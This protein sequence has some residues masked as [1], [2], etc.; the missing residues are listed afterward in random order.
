MKRTNLKKQLLSILLLSSLAVLPVVTSCK[1][2]DNNDNDVVETPLDPENDKDLRNYLLFWSDEFEGTTLNEDDW[3]IEVNGNGGGNNEMQFYAAENVTIGE[4]PTTKESCLIL[5]ARKESMYGKNATSGRVNTKNKVKFQYGRVDARIKPPK[6]GNGLWPAYWFMGDDF[7]TKGWPACGEIDAMELGHSNG[8]N[9]GTQD[10]Y[11]ISALHYGKSF[12]NQDY[13]NQ[14]RDFTFESSIQD[15]FHLFTMIWDENEINLYLDLDKNPDATPYASFNITK[16]ES[17][18]MSL[19]GNY[20]HKPFFLIMNL[21]V[22]GNFPG[23]PSHNTDISAVTALNNGDV[24]MYID[25][26]RVYLRK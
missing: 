16:Y 20:F 15:D 24:H 9:N 2:D 22:G 18:D 12:A 8:I 21:A 13:R 14:S 19:V 4:E 23:M 10:R 1:E 17:D 6:T 7:D 26:V 3:N 25:Y 5:T 11:I